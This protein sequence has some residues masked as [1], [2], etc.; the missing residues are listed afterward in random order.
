MGGGEAADSH[1]NEFIDVHCDLA[2][3]ILRWCSY[4]TRVCLGLSKYVS[5]LLGFI[6]QP[7]VKW[8]AASFLV[9]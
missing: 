6:R 3:L 7:R 4:A 1:R 9:A 5:L 8:C 2:I